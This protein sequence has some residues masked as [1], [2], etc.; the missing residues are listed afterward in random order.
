[1]AETLRY[2]PY[3]NPK[4]I[5]DYVPY[6]HHIQAKFYGMDEQCRDPSI[7]YDEVIPELVKAGWDGCLSSEYEGN[8]WIQ[9]CRRSTAANRC[10]AS[11]PCS[12]VWRACRT[13][14]RSSMFDKYLIGEK[15]VRNMGPATAPTGFA[16]DARLGYYRGIG[17]SMIEDLAVTVDGTA[18][19]RDA[20]RFH[21]GSNS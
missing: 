3:A 9:T 6:F 16:F 12:S 7:S 11:M 19:S 20:V 1:M 18:A 15:S 4:R 2:A 13:R 5:K 17:L 8:R 14:R 10:A 21:A